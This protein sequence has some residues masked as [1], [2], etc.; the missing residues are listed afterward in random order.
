MDVIKKYLSLAFKSRV[1]ITSP[2]RTMAKI[3]VWAL[4]LLVALTK[5]R[6][7]VVVVGALA[8]VG[9][10]MDIKFEKG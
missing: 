9:L 8:V 1:V 3:P 7:A 5:H 10:G 6:I 4:V 2:G